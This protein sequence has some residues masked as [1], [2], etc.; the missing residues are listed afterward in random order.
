MFSSSCCFL[1]YIQISQEAGHVVWYSHLIQNFQQFIVIQT[2]KGLCIVNKAKIDVFLE[3]S[4]ISKWVKSH[5]WVDGRRES[6]SSDQ[7]VEMSTGWGGYFI[8]F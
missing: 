7:E 6:H 3:L 1:T 5:L 8:L 2:V 4:G